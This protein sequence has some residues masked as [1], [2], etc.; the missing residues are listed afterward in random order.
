M[1]KR[2]SEQTNK[3]MNEQTLQAIERDELKLANM[4]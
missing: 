2:T 3:W 4:P 1:N